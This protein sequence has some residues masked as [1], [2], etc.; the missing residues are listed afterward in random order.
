MSGEPGLEHSDQP[1]S[2]SRYTNYGA[3]LEE[4][5]AET[6]KDVYG[7]DEPV[8]VQRSGGAIED[9]WR[10]VG[11]TSGKEDDPVERVMVAK[12]DP[13]EGLLKKQV[14]IHDFLALN[15]LEP[16]E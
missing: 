12:T 15:P 7:P 2:E 6:D 11:I 13:K 14:P 1:P 8:R 9:D 3:M 4:I 5:K 10:Y 16:K